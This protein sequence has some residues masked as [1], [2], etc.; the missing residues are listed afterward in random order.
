MKILYLLS[1]IYLLILFLLYKK[2][3]K[4]LCLISSI[5]YSVALLF[6][7]NTAITFSIYQ[8]GINGSFLLYSIINFFIG[9]LI[10]IS[11]LI[12]KTTQKYYLDKKNIMSIIV[13]TLIV[14]LIGY[15]RF[16]GFEAI[17]YES[18]DSSIHYRHALKF[19]EELS[20]LD[21]NNS[22]EPAYGAFIRVMPISY[23]NCGFLMN[24]FSKELSLKVFYIF[25]IITLIL[26]GLIFY[27]TIK[28][29][30][31]K[32]NTLFSIIY[33]IIYLLAFPLNSFLFGFSYLTI[34]IFVANLLYLTI[35]NLTNYHKNILLNISIIFLITM[36]CFHSYYIF[37][38]GIYLILGIY[39]IYLWKKKTI[40]F[41]ELLL[42]GIT[43]LI[44]PF[45]I[46][47][48]YY[49]ITLFQD[50]G[51]SSVGKFMNMWGY[52]YRNVTPISLLFLS[53]VYLAVDIY[54]HKR[55]DIKKLDLYIISIYLLILL[56]TLICGYLELYYFYKLFYLY[57]LL[58]AIHFV[59][60]I[61]EKRK[62]FYPFLIIFSI[63][64]VIS[65]QFSNNFLTKTN[66]YSYN[67]NLFRPERII[68][69]KEEQIILN[70]IKDY[71]DT[72]EVTNQLLML[73]KMD[74]NIWY[75]A[76][77]NKIP[78]FEHPNGDI[79]NVY[80][81]KFYDFK[82]YEENDEFLCLVYFYE[83]EDIT[84]DKTKYDILYE[85]KTGAII[86]RK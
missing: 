62:Y 14:F 6:C 29:K 86:K 59:N 71:E 61:N 33:T 60:K 78:T 51:V 74:K 7:Y 20:I 63:V 9:T 24:Y 83:S 32:K 35:T 73:G 41:K 58:L 21:I 56:F 36:A 85:N 84:I 34:S 25:N 4:P 30:I 44:F 15:I 49:F 19:S 50:S 67:L 76:L 26:N 28:N 11:I 64:N 1:T 54:D 77:T 12:K 23:V 80:K 16:R 68:Y 40:S 3:D 70:K 81:N 43:T 47:F 46:G 79:S 22:R 42:Y 38:P 27:I 65:Y 45:A 66:I 13:I 2:Y 39:Y 48:S 55:F 69:N 31:K 82:E 18:G 72:C 75:Y 57:W 8:I 17:A 5:V 10:L 37:V 53:N 52:S